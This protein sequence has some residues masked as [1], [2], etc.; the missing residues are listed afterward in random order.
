MQ[1]LAS[2]IEDITG[3]AADLQP[4]LMASLIALLLLI[5]IR[6]LAIRVVRRRVSDMAQIYRW[7][8]TITY[9][10]G[11]MAFLIVGRVW[12]AGMSS[13]TTFLG[14]VGAGLAVSMHDTVANITGWF[15]ILMRRP[16]QVGDR[17]EIG[18]DR[19]DVI[20]IRLFQ[21][22]LLEIGNW[23][24]S[25][26]STGRILHIPN[27]LVLR[28]RLSNYTKGFDYIWHEIPVL[29]TF[30]SN[31]QKAKKILAEIA[32]EHSG[33]FVQR[34]KE[35]I[36]ETATEYLIFYGTLTPIVYTTVKDSGVLLTIRYLTPTHKRRNVEELI[37]ESI[38][39]AFAECDDIDY[40][41]PT[42]RYYDNRTE[43]KPGAGALPKS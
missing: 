22:S 37:W 18:G 14:L 36:E 20:D 41:Y 13:L 30:E 26:Q 1:N 16:F 11:I 27:G 2:T 5:L 8:R 24:D 23:V 35:Q 43:G 42:L 21:F 12:F 15:F 17:I 31:W 38:L 28:T 9:A 32:D 34:A 6:M 7:H 39:G 10:T 4:N 33:K 25:D 40:A 29:L 19:G 3:I